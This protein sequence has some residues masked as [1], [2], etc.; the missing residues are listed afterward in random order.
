MQ[1]TTSV[2]H[3][4][5]TGTQE[6]K[7]PACNDDHHPPFL[8]QPLVCGQLP[9]TALLLLRLLLLRLLKVCCCDCLLPCKLADQ[10][11]C[12]AMQHIDQ[13]NK[14]DYGALLGQHHL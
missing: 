4:L 12:L 14:L 2:S 1:P 10:R 5:G 11:R 9:V 7:S 8:R 13:L 3:M 6:C